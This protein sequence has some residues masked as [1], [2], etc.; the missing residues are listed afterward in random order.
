MTLLEFKKEAESIIFRWLETEGIEDV[1]P[2]FSIPPS[3]ELGDLSTPVAMSLTKHLKT[4]PVSIADRIKNEIK[5]INL[6]QKIEVAKPGY[7]NF[8]VN[9]NKLMK[10]TIQEMIEKR[11]RY[12]KIDLK[13][14]KKILI[15]HTSVNPNK[16]LHIGHARNVVLG[17][18]LVNMLKF[19]GREVE[20]VN[21]ID[22]TGS[23]VAD[24]MLGFLELGFELE[25]SRDRFDKY[26]GDEIYVKVTDMLKDSEELRNKRTEISKRID[27]GE[28]KIEKTKNDIVKRILQEQLKTCF[29]IGARYDVLIWESDVLKSGLWKKA[30]E[31]MKEKEI[32][33][34]EKEGKFDG[35]WT[36]KYGDQEDEK[37]VII[38]SDGTTT[39]LA[40]DIAVA[41]WKIGLI[42][43]ILKFKEYTKNMDGSI[44]YRS[45]KNGVEQEFG[46]AETA[47]TLIDVRQSLFQKVITSIMTKLFSVNESEKYFH[48]KYEI[49]SLSNHTIDKYFGIKSDSKF[50]HMSGRKGIYLNLDDTLD[51]MVNVAL[52]ETKKRNPDMNE[53]EL[54][55]IAEKIAISSL[56]YPLLSWDTDKILV[57][58]IDKALNVAEE[59]GSYILYGYARANR[60]LKKAN[61][62]E[63]HN[64]YNI[65][66]TEKEEIKMVK[67]ISTFPIIIN[68]TT[69]SWDIKTLSRFM[70]QLTFQFN[71]FYEKCP[72]LI[73]DKEIRTMRLMIVKSYQI[74]MKILS[75]LLDIK[76]VERL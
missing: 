61:F 38:K 48:Y 53:K 40:K 66:F 45:D 2:S 22:D 11:Q 14:R 68:D 43:S 46:S 29:R 6:I 5:P 55:K 73:E 4:N 42:K 7:I 19:S 10:L 33:Q 17:I 24:I 49:V 12:G 3:D 50:I 52:T 60:I 57:I 69:Q 35:C 21:Y 34:F 65:Q 67:M 75:E 20:I 25:N 27:K 1:I 9:K 30:F 28:E 13:E 72:V 15:E 39:Y 44:I 56:K 47:I 54:K 51:L 70:Y 58:D 16:A 37:E 26:C 36:V 23:Q 32:I 62:E 8:F 71:K 64:E 18:A 59:S 41:M 63:L 74:T 31:I 76:L